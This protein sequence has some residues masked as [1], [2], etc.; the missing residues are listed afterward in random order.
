MKFCGHYVTSTMELDFVM[1]IT[2]QPCG[3]D[4]ILSP[5]SFFK[6]LDSSFSKSRGALPH[7]GPVV[8]RA[9]NGRTTLFLF[10]M[11]EP[12]DA[13]GKFSASVS[14]CLTKDDIPGAKLLK[15]SPEECN[16]WMLRRWLQCRGGPCC[17][18]SVQ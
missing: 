8:T 2:F 9:H 1:S 3:T 13:S 4:I 7:H 18:A 15:G 5:S 17:R 16:C 12:S 11:V 14:V 6:N 10:N